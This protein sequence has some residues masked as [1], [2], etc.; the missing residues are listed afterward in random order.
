MTDATGAGPSTTA[1]LDAIAE[2][3]LLLASAAMAGDI[4]SQVFLKGTFGPWA[5]E[6]FRN[7]AS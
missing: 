4:E 1:D 5:S 7:S 3:W 2:F 6:M